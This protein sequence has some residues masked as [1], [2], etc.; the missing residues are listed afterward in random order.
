MSSLIILFAQ[1]K[2]I[3]ILEILLM[4][5]GAATIGYITAW[6]FYKSVYNK[7]VKALDAELDESKNQVSKLN[8]E[9]DENKSQAFKLNA[10]NSILNK[11]LANLIKENE[12]KNQLLNEKDDE[13]AHLENRNYLPD[14][15]RIGTATEAEKDD[16]QMIS[17]IGPI[18]EENLNAIDIF[19]F[20][21]ISKFTKRDIN[22]IDNAIISFSGRIERDEWVAQAAE[23][24]ISED[25]RNELLERIRSRKSKTLYDRIGTATENEADDLTNISGIGKWIN[26]KLNALAIFTYKQI[27][28]FNE[29]DID[30]VTEAIEYFPGRIERDEWIIQAQELVRIEGKKAELLKQIQKK[31]EIISYD[32]LGVAQKHQ[33]NNLTLINGISIWIEERLNLL[34]IYTFEQISRL[35]SKDIQLISEILDLSPDRIDK[36]GWVSQALEFAKKQAKYKVS[37]SH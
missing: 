28:R 32:D 37:E 35:K 30:E 13:L 18:I 26:K 5:V 11:K 31:K 33:A 36:E 20:L 3:A 34:E 10:E 4:L 24:V 22:A 21:Q 27:S 9:L 17:G 29:D 7:K 16:L 1:T 6:L 12:Q 23:L 14:Y 8:A 19:T 25:K 2:G 15:D